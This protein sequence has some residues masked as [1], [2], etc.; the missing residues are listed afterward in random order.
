MTFYFIGGEDHDFSRIGAVSVDTA[1][2][3]A[4]RTANARCTL[5]VGS[6]GQAATDG[7]L[8]S[9]TAAQTSFWW[10][11]RMYI[12]S[13]TS[14]SN[15][16]FD[17]VPFLD[18]SVRRLILGHDGTGTAASPHLRL[19]KQ[20][21][22]GVRTTLATSSNVIA[23]A[24][25]YKLDI[26]VSSYGAT[27]TVDVYMDGTLWLTFTGD[28]TTDSSTSLSGFAM[29]CNGSASTN[30]VL[31]SEIIC[32]SDDTRSRSLVTLPPAANGNAW[33]WS[34]SFANVDETT[35]DDTDIATSSSAGDVA[36]ATVTSTGITGNP[37]IHAVCVSARAQK[38]GTGPQNADLGVRTGGNDYWSADLALPAAQNRI[39]NIWATNPATSGNWAYTDLTAAGFNI[40]VKSVT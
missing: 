9:F 4:R 30:T 15:T 11:A 12:T 27:G 8:A 16:L 26:H 23:S 17:V 40:G 19:Y 3:A 39:A 18:G 31:W 7:W 13:F 20:S 38:G 34:N 21:A 35:T 29:G 2:T 28:L 6:S 32:A 33:A 24:N 14:G 22:A 37:A 1:T 5:K 36:Q 25:L 10:T